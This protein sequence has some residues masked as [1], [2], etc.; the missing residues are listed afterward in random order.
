ML[1]VFSIGKTTPQCCPL[2]SSRR[3]SA[4]THHHLPLLWGE[5]ND[6]FWFSGEIPLL[7]G[8]CST[9]SLSLLIPFSVPTIPSSDS[10]PPG[11]AWLICFS[12]YMQLELIRTWT[13]AVVGRN[14]N[15]R[16]TQTLPTPTKNISSTNQP[17]SQSTNQPTKK[18]LQ[19][20]LHLFL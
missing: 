18:V 3:I 10:I 5:I 4:L 1:I 15:H 11:I 7:V 6:T 9:K 17:M 19:S 2:D 8:T 20:K 14:Q 13:Q 12:G 16:E